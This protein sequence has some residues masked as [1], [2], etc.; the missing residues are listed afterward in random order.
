[1][2]FFIKDDKGNETEI[3]SLYLD[4]KKNDIILFKVPRK[5]S[6]DSKMRIKDELRQVFS[7]N[8]KIII[9]NDD[10]EVGVIKNE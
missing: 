8:N 10:I 7:D 4:V 5:L 3:E 6:I 9:M 2:K 1:M